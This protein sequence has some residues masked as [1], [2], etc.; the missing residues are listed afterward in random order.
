MIEFKEEFVLIESQYGNFYFSIIKA[1]DLA[2]A[3]DRAETMAS[4]P[5]LHY[6]VP[7]R[8]LEDFVLNYVKVYRAMKGGGKI[9]KKK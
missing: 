6:I 4:S 3:Y 7:L 9:R 1:K 5:W 8:E 2:D